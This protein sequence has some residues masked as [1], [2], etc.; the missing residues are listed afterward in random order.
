MVVQR[1]SFIPSTESLG[2]ARLNLYICMFEVYQCISYHLGISHTYNLYIFDT[3]P[4]VWAVFKRVSV[5]H[6][7]HIVLSQILSRCFRDHTPGFRAMNIWQNCFRGAFAVFGKF[8]RSKQT[9]IH[10]YICILHIATWGWV[11]TLVPSEPQVIAGIYGCSSH[12]SNVSIGID[13]YP[14]QSTSHENHH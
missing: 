3:Y 13:P 6:Y 9:V 2:L 11:K 4:N 7:T 8:F 10:V 1:I 14:I 12:Y 5:F